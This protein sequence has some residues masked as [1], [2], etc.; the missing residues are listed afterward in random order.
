M[1]ALLSG[2]SDLG[3]WCEQNGATALY[4][5][6]LNGHVEVCKLLLEQGADVNAAMQVSLRM[7]GLWLYVLNTPIAVMVSPIY[8]FYVLAVRCV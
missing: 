6:S 8:V 7:F 4:A 1:S 5:A 2:V 3:A